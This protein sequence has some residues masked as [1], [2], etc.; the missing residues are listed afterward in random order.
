MCGPE[1]G[2]GLVIACSSFFHSISL[3]A[4]QTDRQTQRER[5]SFLPRVGQRSRITRPSSDVAQPM[6]RAFA[7][8][9]ASVFPV[10]LPNDLP[11]AKSDR[12][13]KCGNPSKSAC[14]AWNRKYPNHPI[15]EQTCTSKEHHHA[16]GRSPTLPPLP[17][18][19]SALHL[20][21]GGG[22]ASLLRALHHLVDP[23]PYAYLR[24][25]ARSLGGRGKGRLWRHLRES[26]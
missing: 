9:W 12:T 6:G 2:G 3:A 19:S 17:L 26:G 20:C 13:R 21:H 7:R 5:E 15:P 18:T 4:G 24:K 23:L 1:G 14:A 8:L 16:Q 22:E 10:D 25:K 11:N